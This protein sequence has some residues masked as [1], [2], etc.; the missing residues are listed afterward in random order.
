[1]YD[2]AFLM[3]IFIHNKSTN[4]ETK[5]VFKLV[6][7]NIVLNDKASAQKKPPNQFLS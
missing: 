4:Q 6:S 3:Q 5:H 1:M 2:P 7:Y